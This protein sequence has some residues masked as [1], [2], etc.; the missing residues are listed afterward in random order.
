M[1]PRVD[2]GLIRNSL[3]Q[4][5]DATY[6]S[7]RLHEFTDYLIGAI[8]HVLIDGSYDPAVERVFSKSLHELHACL[9]GS[10]TSEIPYE[11][12]S[13]L[14]DALSRWSFCDVEIITHITTGHDFF[15]N[16]FGHWA[17]VTTALTR[18]PTRA[19]QPQLA[20]VGV[21]RLYAHK[22]LF[23]TPLYHELGH[24]IDAKL[25]ITAQTRLRYPNS[26]V[27]GFGSEDHHRREYFAD[28]FAASMIG[29]CSIRALQAIAPNDP[30][31][32]THPATDV[33]VAVVEA[34]LGGNSHPVIDTF[35]GTLAAMGKPLLKSSFR[36]VDLVEAFGDLRT[37]HIRD[38]EELH[39]IYQAGWDYLFEAI[40]KKH[41]PW[42]LQRLDESAVENITNDLVE[43]SIRNFAIRRKWDETT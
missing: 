37:F 23:C 40:A 34:F 5:N 10:T 29:I 15:F 25:G 2:L 39:G 3:R 43:K 6:F 32:V 17:T 28:L 12:V 13:C 22:P 9:L 21:P 36:K 35:Q 27:V 41:N 38:A 4:L 8:D 11:V 30:P 1:Q 24:F 20:L 7:K 42:R 14:Q 18:M 16:P 19:P 33:R 26:L 31:S